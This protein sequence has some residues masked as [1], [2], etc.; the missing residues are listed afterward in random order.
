MGAVAS[1]LPPAQALRN[2]TSNMAPIPSPSSEDIEETLKHITHAQV[3]VFH[4]GE[5]VDLVS[6]NFERIYMYI[7][8]SFKPSFV[9]MQNRP[10]L[11]VLKFLRQ[12]KSNYKKSLC[13]KLGHLFL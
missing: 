7:V 11:L 12:P 9:R 2:S 6:F 8:F 1:V 13:S 3:T 5:N 10:T 4:T